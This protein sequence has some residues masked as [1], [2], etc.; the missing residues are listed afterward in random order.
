MSHYI[1]LVKQ[2]PDVSQITDN[3]FDP[4]TGILIATV[5]PVSSMNLDAQALHLPGTVKNTVGGYQGQAYLS[6]HGP[7]MA[8]EVRVMG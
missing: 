4:Q 1:V 8:A 7:P 5:W 3:A 2:V 6:D